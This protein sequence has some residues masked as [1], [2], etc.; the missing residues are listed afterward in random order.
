MADYTTT[1]RGHRHYDFDQAEKMQGMLVICDETSCD[2][3]PCDYYHSKPHRYCDDECFCECNH[4]GHRGL[5]RPVEE[6]NKEGDGKPT[7]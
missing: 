3:K 5:C 4:A 1:E 6:V 7:P 2:G